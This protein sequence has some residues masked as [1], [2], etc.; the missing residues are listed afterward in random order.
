ME[1]SGRGT[2]NSTLLFRHLPGGAEE[3]HENVTQNNRFASQHSTS[4]R[5]ADL[6]DLNRWILD[7]SLHS[8]MFISVCY[9]TPFPFFHR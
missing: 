2:A 9:E 6:Q 8:T 7:T 4:I 3:N 1:G 5:N